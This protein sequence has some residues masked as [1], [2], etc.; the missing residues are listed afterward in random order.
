[1]KT[2]KQVYRIFEAVPD[3]VFQLAGLPSPGKCVL[4]SVA[5]K[6]SELT[7]ACRTSLLEVFVSW[8]EQRLSSKSKK[9]IE[10]MLLGERPELEET[11]SGKDPQKVK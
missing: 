1:M 4:R 5:V 7:P 6:Y 11:Q 3:W 9:E 8:L 10:I 2:D